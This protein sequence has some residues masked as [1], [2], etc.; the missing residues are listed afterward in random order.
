MRNLILLT[1]KY[2]NLVTILKEIFFNYT[3][4]NLTLPVYIETM[5]L[6]EN[7]LLDM[8]FERVVVECKATDIEL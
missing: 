7:N 4:Y 1:I 2:I 8:H 3:P 5:N 6:V